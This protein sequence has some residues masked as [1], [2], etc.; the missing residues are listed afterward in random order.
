MKKYEIQEMDEKIGKVE[1]VKTNES[2]ECIGSFA[3]V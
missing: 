3:R 1:E 2:R